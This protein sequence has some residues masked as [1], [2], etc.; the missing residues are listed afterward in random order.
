MLSNTTRLAGNHIGIT[1]VVQQRGF[2]VVNVTHHR[3]NRGTWNQIFGFIRLGI[4][5]LL[6]I[7]RNEFD[8]ETELF[9][10]HHQRLCIETLV[11][12]HHQTQIHA[13]RND[14]RNAHIHHRSQFAYRHEFGHLQDA[15]FALFT[16]VL[17]LHT[18]RNRFTFITTVFGCFEFRSFRGQT[19]QCILNLLLY[20]FVTY[21]NMYRSRF[22][23]PL[24]SLFTVI[25]IVV[26]AIVI[27]ITCR[28]SRSTST[29]SRT[30]LRTRTTL[31]L[32]RVI[33]VHL[34]LRDP[35]TLFASSEFTL[36]LKQIDVNLTQH[37]RA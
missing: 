22:R 19:G 31:S 30:T 3:H 33:Q 14:V 24:L 25:I 4:D 35:F 8:L 16:S 20:L 10:H 21:L 23:I 37:L 36:L 13:G 9:G 11:D 34:I 18:G 28:T 7:D 6:R 15:L 12:R 2:T 17:L 32:F 5:R 29:S 1:N 27:V 26:V